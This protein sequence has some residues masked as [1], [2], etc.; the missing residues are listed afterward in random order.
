M[1]RD[2]ARDL[3]NSHVAAAAAS[4]IG[5]GSVAI[6]WPDTPTDIP[7]GQPYIRPTIRHATGGQSSLS[8]Q[9]GIRKFTHAGVLIVQLFAPVGDGM[10][11]SDKMTQA[12][13]TYFETLRSSQVW[14][15]NIRATEIGKQGSAEQ[16]NFLAE[17][18]YDIHH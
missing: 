16:V 9:S 17:F 15:R 7:S 2:E 5:L 3:I 14:Y 1:T 13:L 11:D 12:F 10:T 6:L 8:D 4:I 18:S